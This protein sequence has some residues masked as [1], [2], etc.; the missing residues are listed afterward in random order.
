MASGLMIAVPG[1]SCRIRERISII[2]VDSLR[3]P[4][5]FRTYKNDGHGINVS[6]LKGHPGP[7][8]APRI[9]CLVVLKGCLS[10]VGRSSTTAL[11]TVWR[12]SGVRP[13]GNWLLRG[14]GELNAHISGPHSPAARPL[15]FPK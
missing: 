1:L 15:K 4:D 6:T 8:S 3:L 12:T 11:V 7:K 5:K 9:P 10:A 14:L 2:L 13:A